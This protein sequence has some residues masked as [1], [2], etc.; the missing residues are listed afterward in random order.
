MKRNGFIAGAVVIVILVLAALF[1]WRTYTANAAPINRLQTTPVQRGTLVATV[2]AAG[3]VA[4]AQTAALGFQTTGKVA[5]VNV[6]VGDTVQ[7][8]QVLMILDAMDLNLALKQAQANLVNSQANLDA[9]QANSGNQKD[10]LIAAKAAVDKAKSA[11]Q[12]AQ[13]AY[14][15]IGGSTKSQNLTSGQF[16]ALQQANDDYQSAVA[17]YMTFVGTINNTAIRAAQAQVDG[18][19]VAVNQA[20]NNLAKTQLIAPFDGVVSAVNY[21]VGD[22]V[23]ANA[24]VSLANLSNLQVQVTIAEVDVPRIKVGETAQMTLDALPGRTYNAKVS[25]LD[26][27]GTVTQGVVNYPVTM[28]IIDADGAIHPGMTANLNIVV[29]Q[30]DNVLIVPTRA[31]H[32]QG[33]QKTVTILTQGQT[34]QVPVTTGLT[35]DQN[36]EITNGLAEGDTV[37][38]SQTQ[39]QGGNG[40]GPGGGLP[41]GGGR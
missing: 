20:L 27:V 13:A 4:T 30:R 17:N 1:G 18:A 15:S 5:Q 19:Q 37:V 41:F 34:K 23:S 38:V 8:G 10:Q 11:Q 33:N 39:T 6:Q 14:D 3:N 40:R 25:K 24:A 31:V 7:K 36:V 9:V 35:N 28:T 16:Y 21:N 32:T 29:A 22:T 12:Q 2:N 26:P